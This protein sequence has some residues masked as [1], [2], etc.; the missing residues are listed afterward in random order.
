MIQVSSQ[1]LEIILA[2][3][4][5][6]VPAQEVWVFGSRATGKAKKF[7]DLD[8]VIM[9]NEPLSLH[10]QALLSEDFE[11]SNLSFKVDIVDW[12][13]TSPS[14]REIILRDKVRLKNSL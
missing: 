7:S 3:L 13:T 8:L 11:N 6:H 12:A 5:R 4:N 1:E 14:F 2:I 10:S 9:G